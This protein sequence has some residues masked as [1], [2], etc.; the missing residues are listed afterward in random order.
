M[1]LIVNLWR[2]SEHSMLLVI[3]M[4]ITWFQ[5]VEVV[6]FPG[7]AFIIKNTGSSTASNWLLSAGLIN[8]IDTSSVLTDEIINPTAA[9]KTLLSAVMSDHRGAARRSRYNVDISS[10]CRPDRVINTANGRD[11]Q[12]RWGVLLTRW[13]VY[14][15]RRVMLLQLLTSWPY[16]TP[17]TVSR[18]PVCLSVCWSP[19]NL[20]SV[21]SVMR[22][23]LW[24]FPSGV[25]VAAS[26][27][28]SK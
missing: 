20:I 25:D 13:P 23:R 28:C 12:L 5:S 18:L 9:D 22:T 17:S 15:L 19:L 11:F 7:R 26:T 2:H 14:S 21:G 4:G 6:L 16:L 8:L 24:H 3:L 27:L 1:E 10:C